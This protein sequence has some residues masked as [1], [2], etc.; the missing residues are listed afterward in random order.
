MREHNKDEAIQVL[1]DIYSGISDGDTLSKWSR[2]VRHLR[3]FP[4]CG[5]VS[6]VSVAGIAG[7]V[8]LGRFV[9]DAHSYA[10]IF[11]F[12][13]S[14]LAIVGYVPFAIKLV[15]VKNGATGNQR[16]PVSAPSGTARAS[17]KQARGDP[18]AE[19]G[20]LPHRSGEASPGGVRRPARSST[21]SQGKGG[22]PQRGRER[23]RAGDPVSHR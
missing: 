19:R 1:Q 23:A 17:T 5:W 12:P 15:R 9:V 8:A 22:T 21:G 7:L 10:A 4:A 3:A 2:F 16:S 20:R 14:I 6:I 18:G 11:V 13:G